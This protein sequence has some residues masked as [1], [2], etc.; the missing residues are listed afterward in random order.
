MNAS[1][2]RDHVEEMVVILDSQFPSALSAFFA[3]S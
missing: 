3:L 1:Q 2:L